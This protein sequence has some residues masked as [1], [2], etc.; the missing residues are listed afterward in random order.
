MA[1]VG[2]PPVDDINT[3][4]SENNGFSLDSL[5]DMLI[6]NKEIVLMV[7]VALL[8]YYLYS[9]NC[10]NVPVPSVTKEE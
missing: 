10:I 5:K 7:L 1:E 9:Q 2:E 4:S 8:A 6:E 3:D